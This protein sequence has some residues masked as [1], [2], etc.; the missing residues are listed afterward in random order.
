MNLQGLLSYKNFIITLTL[1]TIYGSSH[2]HLPPHSLGG[3][4]SFQPSVLPIFVKKASVP[5]PRHADVPVIAL[6]AR[7]GDRDKHTHIALVRQSQLNSYTFSA[8][9]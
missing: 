2:S 9:K 6:W 7:E 3:P 5:R 1:C 4:T 8:I